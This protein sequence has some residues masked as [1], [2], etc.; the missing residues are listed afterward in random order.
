[1]RY[2]HLT[3]I[4]LTLS[5]ETNSD[6]R[7][8]SESVIQ[9]E[10]VSNTEENASRRES[11]ALIIKTAN[12]KF[13]V[14]N[15]EQSTKRI[16][17][18]ATKH[19]AFIADMNLVTTSSS[20]T[21]SVII[22]VPSKNFETLI[23]N[24]GKESIFTNFKRISAQDVTEEFLDIETRLQTK[25][26]VRDRY[27]DILR[28]KAK[29]V[30]DVLKAEEQIRILQEEIES[31]EGRLKYLQNRVSLSTINLEIYQ[32]VDYKETP[33]TYEKPYVVKAKDGLSNGWRIVTRF[34]LFVLNI[35]PIILI[36]LLIYWK[37]EWIKTKLTSKK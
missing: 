9:A 26:E 31:E 24:L 27:V 7:D 35:W 3:L 30:E 33:D 29:T 11:E 6:K 5:C 14:E 10:Q 2:L 32:K 17:A 21:N 23:E 16:E 34:S 20:I 13:Q 25:K 22:R 28:N 4:L 1:M 19:Q 15:V 18:F 37:R 12:Y 8:A 36:G